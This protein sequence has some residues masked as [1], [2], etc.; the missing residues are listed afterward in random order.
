MGAGA[1]TRAAGLAVEV[2]FTDKRP[3]G[4]ESPGAQYFCPNQALE[5]HGLSHE[6]LAEAE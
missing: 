2:W 5:G 3:L 6:Q 4:N 1:R